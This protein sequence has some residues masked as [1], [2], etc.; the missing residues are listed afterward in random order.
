MV[1]STEFSNRLKL[2]MQHHE[3]NASQLADKLQVGRSSI[4]HILSGRNKPS[5]DF[6]LSLV[7][8]FQEVDLYWLT[9][10]KGSFPSTPNATAD[11]QTDDQNRNQ[12]NLPETKTSDPDPNEAEAKVTG[13]K[14]PV[15]VIVLY[16]DGSFTSYDP[17]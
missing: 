2:I 13:S 11:V 6:I 1:N 16:D 14:K 7:N 17:S 5:L 15:K 9:K 8:H 3:L 12:E 10:G 4:S